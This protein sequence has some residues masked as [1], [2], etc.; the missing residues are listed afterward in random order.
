MVIRAV[1][2][3]DRDDVNVP[4]VADSVR[5]DACGAAYRKLNMKKEGKEV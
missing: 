2:L 1:D 3:R 4:G 5:E